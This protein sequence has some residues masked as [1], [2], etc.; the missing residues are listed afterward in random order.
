MNLLRFT[1][2]GVRRII[3]SISFEFCD[4]TKMD[5]DAIVNASDKKLSGGGGIDKAIHNAAGREE[6]KDVLKEKKI[7]TGEAIITPGFKLPAKYIIHTAG[8]KYSGGRKNE[9]ELLK[10]AY[11]SCL[12]LAKEYRL[13]AIAFCS[14]STGVFRYPLEEA[15]CIAITTI[16]EWYRETKYCID[17]KFAFI[18]KRTKSAYEHIY[19]D[20]IEKAKRMQSSRKYVDEIKG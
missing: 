13:K 20:I 16:Q 9:K 7:D 2:V 12:N 1:A 5:V 18:D 15:A 6:L 14:I 4:I 10:N 19:E 11:R 3:M 8:P 17:V